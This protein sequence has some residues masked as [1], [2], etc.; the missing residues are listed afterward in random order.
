MMWR[1]LAGAVAVGVALTGGSAFAARD[2]LK[3]GVAQFP[4]N[5]HPAVEPTVVKSY[6]RNMALRQLT[7]WNKDWKL[8][9]LLCTELPTIENGLAKIE[10]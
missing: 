3:I 8:G 7:G 5:M 2:E 10:D 9:C 1:I 6:V 4:S